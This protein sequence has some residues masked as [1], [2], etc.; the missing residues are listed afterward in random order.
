MIILDIEASGLDPESYPIEI[1]WQHRSNSKLFDS[2]LI[3]PLETWSHW[4]FY[5]E[6]HFHRLSRSDLEVNG[7]SVTEATQRL[8]QSLSGQ[9]VYTDAPDYDRKWIGKLF[10]SVGIEKAFMIKSLYTLIP[11]SRECVYRQH[12]ARSPIV[13]RALEDVRQIVKSLNYVCPE[14]C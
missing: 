6:A 12:L 5:A 11:P 14:G 13:H 9:T 1:A 7:I 8:N 3:K 2:F 10:R 4:D